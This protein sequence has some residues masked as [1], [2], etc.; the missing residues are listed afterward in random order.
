MPTPTLLGVGIRLRID[1]SY[2]GG[3]FSGW[4]RQPELRTVQGEL[5]QA[6][7]KTLRLDQALVKTVVAGRTDAGVHALGQVCHVDLPE[8]HSLKPATLSELPRR[9]QGALRT[10]DIVIHSVTLAPAGF[11]ARFSPVSRTYRYRI[12][13]GRSVKNPLHQAYTVWHDGVLDLRS[14]NALGRSLKG[15]HDWASFCKPRAGSTTI[16]TLIAFTWRRD[17]EGV[18]E[19]TVTADAFCHSM[20]RSLVG[21]AVAV[22]SGKLAV[23]DVVALRDAGSR[24]SAF[25]TMPAH[26]LTLMSVQYPADSKLQAR[27]E[28]T[29]NRRDHAS[30]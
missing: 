22:G 5:E 24:T 2:H 18:L 30:D 29:R 27:A 23:Q 6:L 3:H 19:G 15:L 10:P 25:S 11:D 26:G 7:S 8:G 12:A 1:L 17:V 21:A 13:D 20:V 14:M 28:L 4:A 16:R 9:I